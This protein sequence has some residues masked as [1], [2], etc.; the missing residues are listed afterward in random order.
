MSLA[1]A[2]VVSASLPKPTRRPRKSG[3]KEMIRHGAEKTKVSLYLS[4][5]AARRLAVHA[6]MLGADRSEVA[7]ELIQ[8]GCRRWIVSER[9]S[10]AQADSQEDRQEGT[11]R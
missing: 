11:A 8:A 5:D 3:D 6:T 9:G 10:R 1:T 7:E 4:V 2:V